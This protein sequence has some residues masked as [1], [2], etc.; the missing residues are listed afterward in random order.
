MQLVRRPRRRERHFL[1]GP[2]DLQEPTRQLVHGQRGRGGYVQD[3]GESIVVEG[4]WGRARGA[5]LSAGVELAG[6]RAD[7]AG[8][9]H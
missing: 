8:K 2:I 9:G 6:I 5:V 7:D 3:A 4:F 1:L